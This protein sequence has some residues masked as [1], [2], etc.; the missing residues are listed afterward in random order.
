MARRR[1]KIAATTEMKQLEN[2]FEENWMTMLAKKLFGG[3]PRFRK[4]LA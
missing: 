1:A 3:K 2:H 4:K